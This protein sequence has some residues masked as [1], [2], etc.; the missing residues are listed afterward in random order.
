MGADRLL[1]LH[2]PRY[3]VHNFAPQALRFDFEIARLWVQ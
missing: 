1:T 2:R 3:N